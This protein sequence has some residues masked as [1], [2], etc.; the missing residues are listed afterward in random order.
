[1]N[2]LLGADPEVFVQIPGARQRYISA[3]D[4]VPGTKAKP[5]PV[6]NGA[7]QADGTA[8][9]F[10]I[11]PASSLEEF[12][13]N[14]QSVKGQLLGHLKSLD[15]RAELDFSPVRK[16]SKNY[17]AKKVPEHAKELGCEPDFNAYTRE[18]NPRPNQVA[19]GS[20]RSAGGHIHFGF[21]EVED[22]F[23][24]VH[25]LDCS[26]LTK[27]LDRF[28]LP[29]STSWDTDKERRVLYG[30]P[31]AFRPKKYGM[32][33]RPLSNK[34]VESPDTIAF[35][36]KVSV[37]VFNL[38]KSD[39]ALCEDL[40]NTKRPYTEYDTEVIKKLGLTKYSSGQDAGRTT[41]RYNYEF[42]D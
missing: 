18:T 23:D 5:F 19:A 17:W 7:F 32:E 33:Y 30:K 28:L 26:I 2:L 42:Y 39:Q 20:M 11:T 15:K 10:N 38:L 14:I 34:W 41:F 36:Y 12:T 27:A 31:G 8:A 40:L 24:K 4:I 37:G 35:V 6:A 25:I 22:P 9:E 13:N 1:M 21:T 29:F 16:Y 3:H